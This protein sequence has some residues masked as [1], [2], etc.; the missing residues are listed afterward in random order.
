MRQTVTAIS[1]ANHFAM[2]D[3]TSQRMPSSI[4]ENARKHIRRA[5]STMVAISAIFAAISW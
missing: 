5:A 3:G 1:V 4:I 2:E